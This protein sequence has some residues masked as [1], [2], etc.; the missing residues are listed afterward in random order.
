MSGGRACQQRGAKK[1][2]TFVVNGR[3]H[4]RV[5]CAAAVW[6]SSDTRTEAVRA[7]SV[8]I[9]A[10]VLLQHGLHDH[11]EPLLAP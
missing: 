11:L 9:V 5:G 7:H 1:T 8:H 2:Q 10:V 3:P 4:D 6:H